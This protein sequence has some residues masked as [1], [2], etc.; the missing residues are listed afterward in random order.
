MASGFSSRNK[1]VYLGRDFGTWDS[2]LLS[3]PEYWLG[4]PIGVR[5][6]PGLKSETWGTRRV[7]RC[8]SSGLMRSGSMLDCYAVNLF[9]G[10]IHRVMTLID[11]IAVVPG[12]CVEVVHKW[13]YPDILPLGLI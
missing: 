8:G 4:F 10:A 6:I 1:G 2:N 12:K 9:S 3:Y 5:A 11:Y 7:H 13:N